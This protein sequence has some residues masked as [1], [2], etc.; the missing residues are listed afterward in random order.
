ML[1]SFAG[2]S[3]ISCGNHEQPSLLKTLFLLFKFFPLNFTQCIAP[4]GNFQT[5]LL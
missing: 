5:S 4:F 1:L 3:A 2:M